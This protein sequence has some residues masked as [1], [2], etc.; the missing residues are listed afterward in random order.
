[1]AKRS[2]NEKISLMTKVGVSVN[3]RPCW[4]LGLQEVLL[5]TWWHLYLYSQHTKC[6]ICECTYT[7]RRTSCW[8]VR[9]WL[10]L[11]LLGGGVSKHDYTSCL[12]CNRKPTRVYCEVVSFMRCQAQCDD[13]SYKLNHCYCFGMFPHFWG[14]AQ[15]RNVLGSQVRCTLDTNC[16]PL[17]LWDPLLN[18]WL[19]RLCFQIFFRKLHLLLCFYL[20]WSIYF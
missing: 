9:S 2:G 14:H 1:M 12:V 8:P 18:L 10:I 15:T 20:Y 13:V 11:T 4:P 19:V 6:L 5:C 3:K 16:V 7:E 17:L